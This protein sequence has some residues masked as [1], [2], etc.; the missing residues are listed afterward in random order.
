MDKLSAKAFVFL[1]ILVGLIGLV[2]LLRSPKSFQAQRTKTEMPPAR[3]DLPQAETGDWVLTHTENTDTPPDTQRATS[4][5]T[6]TNSTSLTA[7]ATSQA[8]SGD[9]DSASPA[10][11]S[12][13]GSA[14]R[15]VCSRRE[16]SINRL[17]ATCKSHASGLSGTPFL[18]RFRG[19]QPA[20]R[21]THPAH[22]Q[23]RRCARRCRRPVVHTN[24]A[25]RLQSHHAWRIRSSL[26][27]TSI[28]TT[29][30]MPAAIRKFVERFSDRS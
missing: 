9:D 5:P 11:C 1:I 29:C 18:A 17:R 27:I 23:C 10:S 2:W 7:L 12:N 22:R 13:K 30:V 25:Q 14:S 21:S 28:A 8:N 24:H 4:A 19:L 20:P 26:K 16:A 3:D 15:R 6:V